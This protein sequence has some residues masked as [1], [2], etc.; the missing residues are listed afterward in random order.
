M[1]IFSGVLSVDSYGNPK[2]F[3]DEDGI[4]WIYQGSTNGF[5]YWIG[6]PNG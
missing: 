1:N 5:D 2:N 3:V 6:S 4:Y